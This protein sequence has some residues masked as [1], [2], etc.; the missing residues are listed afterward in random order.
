MKCRYRIV[1][2]PANESGHSYRVQIS[3]PAPAGWFLGWDYATLR[4]FADV[5]S[6]HEEVVRWQ[7]LDGKGI[8]EVRRYT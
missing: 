4:G 6:A 1:R 8:V 7:A 2:V 5:E 3:A